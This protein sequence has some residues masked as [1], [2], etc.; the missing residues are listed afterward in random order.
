M[1]HITIKAATRFRSRFVGAY[2]LL[3]I[4]IGVFLLFFRGRL[5]FT[6]DIIA[7]VFYVAATALFYD[8]SKALNGRK[9]R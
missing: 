5:A 1:S 4:L 6:V 3:T 9:G 7:T 8:L 2:Y